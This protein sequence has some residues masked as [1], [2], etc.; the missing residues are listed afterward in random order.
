MD[1]AGSGFSMVTIR[2]YMR[3]DM[4][5]HCMSHYIYMHS[6]KQKD[7]LMNTMNSENTPRP[8]GYW[9]KATD[10]LMAAEF[11]AAFE[12]EGVTRREWRMLNVVDG[13]VESDRPLHEHKLRRL[14]ELGWVARIDG[15]WALTEDGRSAKERLGGIVDGIRAKVVDAVSPEDLGTTLATL[16]Q[17]ARAFGWDE[18]TRLPRGRGNRHDFGAH[19]HGEHGFGPHARG[20]H[21]FGR[22]GRGERAH[23]HPVGHE[24]PN[25]RDHG[26]GR[27][28][29][30]AQGA[31]ERGFDAG[32]SRGRDAL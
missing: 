11:A 10:R 15:A 25:H 6:Y 21:G 16:E 8:F 7:F 1:S 26:R 32:F 24:H 28:V 12:S 27:F 2:F 14:I 17:I 23:G 13:T 31:Y 5:L 4:Y 3:L 22:P 20:D 29:R 19:R 9:L 18:Q 30:F